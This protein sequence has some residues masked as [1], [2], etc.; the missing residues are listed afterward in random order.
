MYVYVFAYLLILCIFIDRDYRNFLL[1]IQ[2]Q[3]SYKCRPILTSEVSTT[4]SEIRYLLHMG[5]MIE[6]GSMQ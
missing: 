5:E 6:I 4:P 2:C 1:S 3:I